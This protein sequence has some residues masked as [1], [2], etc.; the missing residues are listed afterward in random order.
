[1]GTHPIFESDFDCLTERFCIYSNMP[2]K[3]KVNKKAE[4]KKKEKVID[5]KTFGLKNKKGSKQQ[6]YIENVSK[7]VMSGGKA[8]HERE[9][10]KKRAAEKKA[11]KAAELAEMELLFGKA[12]PAKSKKA[13]IY[14][15]KRD[16]K[17]EEE[18]DMSNWTEE[19]LRE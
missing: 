12:I 6:K 7:Q 18:S 17:K 13:D 4:L 15:D 3:Q 1:M 2:P 11:Q 16:Q 8:G 14:S 19:E 5:D 10:E 9:M